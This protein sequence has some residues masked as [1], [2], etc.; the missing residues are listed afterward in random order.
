M[1][2]PVLSLTPANSCMLPVNAA[3]SAVLFLIVEI[4]RVLSV[5][6]M[7]LLTFLVFL[8]NQ[9]LKFKFRLHDLVVV[10]VSEHRIISISDLIQF[11]C[12]KRGKR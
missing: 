8:E 12:L 5:S 11:K 10:H 2:R 7:H 9:T 3:V 4:V 1:G 6:A